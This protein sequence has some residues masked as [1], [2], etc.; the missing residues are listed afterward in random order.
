VHAAVVASVPAEGLDW[1]LLPIPDHAPPDTSPGAPASPHKILGWGVFDVAHPVAEDGAEPPSHPLWL[2]S[3]VELPDDPW[4][5]GSV[6]AFWSDFGMNWSARA[7][8]N[9][10]DETAVSSLSATHSVWFH[11]RVPTTEWHLFDVHTRSLAGNQGYVQ[12]SLYD[13]AG[14]LAASIAQ[15]VFIRHPQPQRSG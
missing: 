5:H 10:L 13:H 4:L 7:T 15:G 11:R 9:E 3:A 12:A 14:G 6:K 1:Q 2:R 8:H